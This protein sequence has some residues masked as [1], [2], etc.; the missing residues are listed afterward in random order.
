MTLCERYTAAW[1]LFHLQYDCML[2]DSAGYS[3]NYLRK[4]H[5][6][7]TGDRQ[8][9]SLRHGQ[10]SRGKHTAAG[11]AMLMA[12]GHAVGLIHYKD[13]VQIFADIQRHL[14][15]WNEQINFFAHPD[16]FPPIEDL[17]QFE[18]LAIEVYETAKKLEPKQ[19]Q[20]SQIFDSLMD[21]NRKRNLRGTNK[22][23]QSRIETDGKLNPY[24]SLV[25]AIERYVVEAK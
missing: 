5:V 8:V 1:R 24:V 14:G 21:M 13:C 20:R 2:P 17:R 6:N 7:V 3:A 22:W 18:D 15:D 19:E 11:L 10:L 16:N 23:L 12:E 4:N 9:D 25:D